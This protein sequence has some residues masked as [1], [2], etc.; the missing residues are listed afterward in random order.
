MTGEYG[1][2]KG[3]A[4]EQSIS[5]MLTYLGFKITRELIQ[6]KCVNP[7]HQ[8]QEHSVDFLAEHVGKLPRPFHSFG[9]L[10]FLD[11]TASE[12][13]SEAQFTKA[14]QT[15]ECLR[16]TS[17]FSDAKGAIVVTSRALTPAL[18]QE[19]SNHKDL[20]CWDVSRLNLYGTMAE[21]HNSSKRWQ[22]KT[23]TSVQADIS[24]VAIVIRGTWTVPTQYYEGNIFY[25]GEEPLNRDSL[26]DIL[27]PL[28]SMTRLSSVAFVR[29]HS[30]NGFTSD[31]PRVLNSVIKDSSKR[32]HRIVIRPDDLYDYTR[33]WFAAFSSQQ[34]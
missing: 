30:L 9:G 22:F 2:R 17:A 33:P 10:T 23:K 12:N 27:T 6:I 28:S 31:I 25:E 21:V 3:N 19:M 24:T 8:Q 29:V 15:L 13:L 20:L 34:A 14:S 16:K 11:C 26:K 32:L 7:V 4:F 5:A 18:K 1:H